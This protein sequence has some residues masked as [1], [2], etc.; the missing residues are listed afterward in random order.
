M[1]R[2]WSVTTES[3]KRS[4]ERIGELVSKYQTEYEKLYTEAQAL[5]SAKWTG[6]A[7]DTFNKKLEEYKT[8]FEELRDVMNNY[9]EFLKN[10]AEHYE[11]VENRLHKVDS[12]AIREKAAT[13]DSIATN[14]ENYTEEIEREIQGMKSVWEGDAAESSVAKFENFKRAFA[15][16]KETI[17]NYAQFLRN[18]AE[19][20]DNS[21]RNIQNGANE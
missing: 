1:A 12:T 7:S 8:A 15:E 19:A 16:R 2:E 14:I 11:Q 6:I 4:S 3:V 20:Y 21:E 5:R 18:A 17:R 9:Q 10:A 13:F